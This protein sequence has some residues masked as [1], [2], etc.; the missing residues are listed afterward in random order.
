MMQKEKIINLTITIDI[1]VNKKEFAL[2]MLNDC[3]GSGISIHGNSISEV[4]KNLI[5]YIESYLTN[6]N[7]GK[8]T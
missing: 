1:Q 3:G 7:Y 5:P 2:F 8:E 4:I 6:Y